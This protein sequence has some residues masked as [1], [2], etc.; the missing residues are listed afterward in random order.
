MA[1]IPVLCCGSPDLGTLV[2]FAFAKSTAT[3][4]EAV[5]RLQG[6]SGAA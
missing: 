1:D 4:R 2:R 5:A 3:M 6:A